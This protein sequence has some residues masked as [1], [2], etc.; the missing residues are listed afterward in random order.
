MPRTVDEGFSDF[1][2]KLRATAVESAAAKSHRASIENCLRNNFGLIRFAR[3]GSFGNGTN[4]SGYSD[5]DYIACIPTAQ[6]T[7]TSNASLVKLRVA[8]DTRFPSTGVVVRSPTVTVPFCT[9]RSETTE[10]VPADYVYDSNGFKVYDIPD[11]ANGWMKASPDA[12]NKYVRDIDAKHDGKV[13]PLIRYIKAW[14]YY[15]DVPISSFY[16]EMRVAKY[17]SDESAIFHYMDVHYFL[18]QLLRDGLAD[19]RDPLG[20][21][22]YISACNSTAR[23]ED[24]LSKLATASSRAEKAYDAA[25]GGD[26]SLAFSYWR[27]LYNDKFPTYYR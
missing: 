10:I 9:Y 20:V 11:C 16:L 5:V 25:L 13:K 17:A 19:M 6:L 18:K 8:L 15:R 12:H 7:Q 4:I 14:K 27:L 23:R 3:I 2:V 22:G 26:I 24:A 21:S 1:L